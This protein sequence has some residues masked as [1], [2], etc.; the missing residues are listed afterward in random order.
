MGVECI[1]KLQFPQFTI[2]GKWQTSSASIS[3]VTKI[4]GFKNKNVPNGSNLRVHSFFN[5]LCALIGRELLKQTWLLLPPGC[6]LLMHKVA[7]RHD[8]GWLPGCLP[9]CL[10]GFLLGCLV[11]CLH[12]CVHV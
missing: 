12:V 10:V 3:S 9:G 6:F 7:V 5:N 1:Y 2:I 8:L 11:T 4:N